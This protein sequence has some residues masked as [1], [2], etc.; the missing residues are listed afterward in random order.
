MPFVERKHDP[1]FEEEL[2]AIHEG[3]TPIEVSAV[4]AALRHRDFRVMWMG[5]FAS[6]IGTWMQNVVLGAFAYKLTGSPVFVGI[7]YFGQLGPAL[8]LSIV[9]GALADA[10][11]R[12]RLIVVAQTEQLIATLVLTGVSLMDEPNRVVLFLT[13]FSVGVGNALNAPAWAALAPSLVPREHLGGALSVHAA[14][15]N[16]A[17]VIGPA[18]GAV[19]YSALSV[20]AVFGLN[21]VTYLFAIAAVL[22]VRPRPQTLVGNGK[23]GFARIVEAVR[24]ARRDPLVRWILITIVSFSLLCLPFLGQFP[25]IA[26]DLLDVDPRSGTYGALYATFGFGAIIGGLSI[27]TFLGRADRYVVSRWS[28]LLIAA[29]LAV[30]TVTSSVA[31]AF[32]VAA[33]FGFGYFATTT[34][35]LTILQENL[36]D[37]VRG[38]VLALWQTGWAGMIPLGNLIAG[39]IAQL[40]S[41]RVVLAY[42]VVAALVLAW[43]SA[44]QDFGQSLQAGNPAALDEDDIAFD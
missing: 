7:I 38:R 4:R 17:R 28:I 37:E 6:N 13:V 2:E 11:D 39:P 10:M 31:V 33:L 34:S 40:L 22:S 16:A 27:G 5:S 44:R 18:I 1:I 30:L 25:T 9:G 15:I 8:L 29:M 42:G 3:D 24:F 20:T 14:Q 21:S 32:P 23:P 36:A 26:A 41:I 35:L 19:L 12:R 43:W